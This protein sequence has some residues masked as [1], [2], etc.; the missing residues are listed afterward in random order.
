MILFL[1]FIL[2]VVG[3]INLLIY[4]ARTRKEEIEIPEERLKILDNG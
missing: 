3:S 4:W 1:S 2:L